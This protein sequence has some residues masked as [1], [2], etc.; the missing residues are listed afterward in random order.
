MVLFAFTTRGV[1]QGTMMH[2]PPY[3]RFPPLFSTN[4]RTLRKIFT[5][6]P[7]P[8][9][10]L[11]FHPPKFLTFFSRRPQISNFPPIFAVSVHFPLFHENYY[12][13]PTLPYFPT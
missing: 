9:K 7:C 11:D 5:I 6:L 4:F 12:F 13:P 10:F 8:D 3:F 1:H 2:F